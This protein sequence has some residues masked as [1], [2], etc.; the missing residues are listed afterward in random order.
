LWYFIGVKS[1]FCFTDFFVHVEEFLDTSVFFGVFSEDEEEV[2]CFY[3]STMEQG[4]FM[5]LM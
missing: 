5:S 3:L 2:V 1:L 4:N